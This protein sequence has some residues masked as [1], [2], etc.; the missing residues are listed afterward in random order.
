MLRSVAFARTLKVVS[1][2]IHP[3]AVSSSAPKERPM[4]A[5]LEWH[6]SGDYFE[7]CNCSI[8]C[9]CFV[10]KNAPLT[11]RPSEGVCDVAF[12]FHIESGKYDDTA[13]DGLNVA[14]AVHA[15]GPMA[16]GNWSVAAYIDQNANDK[17]TEALSAIFSGA[18]GGPIAQLAP[19]IG[20]NLGVKKVPITY[21]VEGKKRS[22]EIP[23]ILHMTVDPLPTAHPSGEMWANVGH[24]VNPD[25]LAFA[26]GASGNVFTDHGMRW[27]NSG[28]NG[29]YAPI[30]WSNR[31]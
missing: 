17:Q 16:E 7:N 26:V 8:V 11:S 21:R 25:K 27:D 1:S 20:N 24:P 4:A 18:A 29:Q 2:N 15:P 22:A 28:K 10:S 3:S 12:I 19:L 30:R 13:L 14:L 9:P 5:Q 6:L 23:N 31:S